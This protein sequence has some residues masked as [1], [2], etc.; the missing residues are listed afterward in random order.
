MPLRDD[1]LDPIAGANPSGP[2]LRYDPVFDQIKE[3]RREEDDTLPSGDWGRPAK[4]ADHRMVVKLAGE[5]L[6]K[7]TKDLRLAASLVESQIKLEGLA[8]LAPSIE[9]LRNL[10]EKFWDTLY[11][12]FDREDLQLRVNEIE[13]AARR[14]AP[15]LVELPL[16]SNGLTS[17]GYNE[18]RMVGAKRRSKRRNSRPKSSTKL[19]QARRR[20]SMWRQR[21]LSM[22][23]SIK[24]ICSIAFS[25][26]LTAKNIPNSPL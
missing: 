16:T 2:D 1:L 10:Q 20:R 21:T 9:F 15:I 14:V 18:P 13:R 12:E 5:S 22:R 7:R 23:P 4:K 3:A 17:S 6:A 25:A 24:R 26:M 11:P 19:L 8:V